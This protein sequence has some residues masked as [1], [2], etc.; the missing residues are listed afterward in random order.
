MVSLDAFTRNHLELYS[1]LTH[2][3]TMKFFEYAVK[4][5]EVAVNPWEGHYI[6]MN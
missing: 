2:N 3:H 1:A 4:F 5:D 6:T